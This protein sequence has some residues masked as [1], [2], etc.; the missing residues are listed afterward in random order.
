MPIGSSMCVV[1][2]FRLLKHLSNF[3]KIGYKRYSISDDTVM[4]YLIF[5][6]RY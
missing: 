5:Y 6:G 1:A 3:H 2:A 4:F